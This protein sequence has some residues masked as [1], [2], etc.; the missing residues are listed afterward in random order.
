MSDVHVRAMVGLACA[1]PEK[2]ASAT[3]AAARN[4]VHLA[5]P[6][7]RRAVPGVGMSVEPAETVAFGRLQI[8]FDGRV[9]R[10][11]S[12][13]EAQSAW[14]AE[15]LAYGA[16]RPGARALRGRRPHRAARGPGLDAR[17]CASTSTRW[18]ATSRGTTPR[19]PG[20]PTGSRSARARWT[21]CCATASGSRW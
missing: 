21:R 12:W 5:T 11:R 20:W 16:R 9:L 17:C 3:R 19:R 8:T 1:A 2:T 14:A 4:A 13:T 15:I 10:P 6:A 7:A 18:R